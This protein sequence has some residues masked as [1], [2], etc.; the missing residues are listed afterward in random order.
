MQGIH[1]AYAIHTRFEEHRC[2]TELADV[3]V[4]HGVC[5]CVWSEGAHHGC[6]PSQQ[7]Q[8][9]AASSQLRPSPG[10]LA[11]HCPGQPSATSRKIR[12]SVSTRGID[13]SRVGKPRPA[14][15]RAVHV[16]PAS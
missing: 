11:R 5:V 10:G 16:V 3:L 2:D 14:P 1:R 6:Y 8:L 4:G 15:S 13:G 7:P 12:G 9:P